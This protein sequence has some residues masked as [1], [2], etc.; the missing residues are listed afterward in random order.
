[1]FRLKSS[2]NLKLQNVEPTNDL[3]LLGMKSLH[4]HREVV[5]VYSILELFK[6]NAPHKTEKY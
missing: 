2:R 4:S 3:Q 1:M 6:M 5:K